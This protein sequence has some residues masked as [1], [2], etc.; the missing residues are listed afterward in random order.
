MARK[1]DENLSDLGDCICFHFMSIMMPTL[2]ENI[3]FIT[4]MR[5]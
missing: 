4:I 5:V 2:W 3:L 1:A